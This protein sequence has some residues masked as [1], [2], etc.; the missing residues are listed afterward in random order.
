[1][2]RKEEE[3][4]SLKKELEAI[5]K[6]AVRG[7]EEKKRLRE[8]YEE[9]VKKITGQLIALKKQRW[10]QES[11]RLERQKAKSDVKVPNIEWAM[12]SYS[13][14]HGKVLYFIEE[15]HFDLI[16]VVVGLYISHSSQCETCYL[17]CRFL[18]DL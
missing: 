12:L 10:E 4:E 14:I 2:R 17:I 9:K 13:F 3:V 18:G 1:M 6:N 11:Q 5:D 16:P 8:Q 7:A 15:T